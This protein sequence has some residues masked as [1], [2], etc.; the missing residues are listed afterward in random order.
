MDVMEKNH[1]GSECTRFLMQ[2]LYNFFARQKK[3]KIEGRDATSVLNHMKV[4]TD[5]DAEFFSS[6][7]WTVKADLRI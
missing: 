2:D 7:A 4:M 6:I 5:K 3:E 1:G